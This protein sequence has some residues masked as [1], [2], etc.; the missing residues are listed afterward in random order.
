MSQ[1]DQPATGPPGPFGLAR[2][3]WML[4]VGMLLNRLG[5]TVYFMLGIYLTRERGLRP[6]VAGV[7]I[8]FYAAGGLFAGPIGGMLADRMGRRSTLLLGTACAGTLM[9]V[10]GFA[11]STEAIVAIAPALGFCTDACRAAL[12]VGIADVVPPAERARA[13]GLLYW[14]TNLGFSVAAA[15]GGGLAEH[16]FTLLFVIDALTTLAYGAIVFVGVSETR[17]ESVSGTA[18]GRGGFAFAGP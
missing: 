13:Y 1:E 3:F 14:A 8:S 2:T 17:P 12:N 5:G 16:H 4:W 18:G 9:L 6:E 11:R 15:F 10:L 7:V